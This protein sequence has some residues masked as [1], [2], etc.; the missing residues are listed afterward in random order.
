VHVY[1]KKVVDVVVAKF[2]LNANPATH[3]PARHANADYSSAGL[4]ADA[5][6][7][8]KCAVV[9]FNITN[10]SPPVIDVPFAESDG[11][12]TFYPGVDGNGPAMDLINQAFPKAA[13]DRKTRV[14]VVKKMRSFYELKKA[15]AAGARAIRITAKNV[16]PGR[17]VR[18]PAIPATADTPAV[19]SEN[20]LTHQGQRSNVFFIS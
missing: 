8:L 3:L 7:K 10:R 5:S 15:A 18:F 2:Q 19:P 1:E 12:L 9:E 20:V 17:P 14:V 16:T 6:D 4:S 13:H 11:L